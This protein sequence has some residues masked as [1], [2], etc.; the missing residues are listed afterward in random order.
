MDKQ[1]FVVLSLT[2][3]DIEIAMAQD[4]GLVTPSPSQKTFAAALSAADMEYIADKLGDDIMNGGEWYASLAYR[5]IE[6][7]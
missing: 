1:T 7:K 2:R 3:E 4:A 5:A 6:L